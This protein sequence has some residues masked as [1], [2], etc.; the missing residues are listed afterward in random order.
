MAGSDLLVETLFASG[1]FTGLA[2]AQY[3]QHTHEITVIRQS[4]I[5]PEEVPGFQSLAP[6]LA[7]WSCWITQPRRRGCGCVASSFDIRSWRLN[8]PLL[9][10]SSEGL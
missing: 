4:E 10:Q 6:L 1:V 7:I 2:L 8:N 9:V 3:F 5:Q